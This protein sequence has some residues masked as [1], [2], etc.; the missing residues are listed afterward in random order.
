MRMLSCLVVICSLLPAAASQAQ[1]IVETD[2]HNMQ[3]VADGVWFAVGNGT[4]YTISNALVIERDEDVVIVDS[5]VTPAAGAALLDS[6]AVVTDKPVT[7]VINS[8]FHYDHAFGTQAFGDDIQ[9]IGHEY[10]RA[11]LSNDP[12]N[13]PTYLRSL[14]R[15]DNTVADIETRL[16]AADDAAER[17]GLETELS[18]W[19]A[20]VSSQEETDP[21]APN[22]SVS[23]RMTLYRGGR[24]IQL[25]WLGRAHTGGD[26]AVY[27]PEEKIVFTGDMMLGRPSYMGDGYVGEWGATLGRLKQL[28]IELVLP[29]HGE[30]FSDLRIIDYVQA[31]YNDLHS[32]VMRLKNQGYPAAEAAAR[33]DLRHHQ[34]S[35]GIS[36]LGAD[37][38]TVQRI[39]DLADGVAE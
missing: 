27:L 5:H 4:V 39:Y 31:Y 33:V 9:V 22:V 32:E 11:R 2:T 1:E 12:L 15:F 30:G 13:D 10:T 36:E 34:D 17:A 37:M 20:H 28:D 16:A 35:L 26:L 24:E 6:I 29:G 8:H 7:T 3:V 14:E 25:V 38:L 23:D 21:V 18:F 19:R